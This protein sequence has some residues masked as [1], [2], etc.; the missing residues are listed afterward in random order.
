MNSCQYC[1]RMRK[2]RTCELSC[3]WNTTISGFARHNPHDMPSVIDNVLAFPSLPP[4]DGVLHHTSLFAP[5]TLASLSCCAPP[6]ALPSPST[7]VPDPP[8]RPLLSHSSS[9]RCRNQ[10]SVGTIWPLLLLRLV[11]GPRY[12]SHPKGS[13][14]R[15][16]REGSIFQRGTVSQ[17]AQARCD[18]GPHA[19]P[20][21][22]RR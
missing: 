7:T 2:A 14:D 15:R 18:S 13:P 6:V 11:H 21:R 17:Q 16:W 9:P 8:F 10:S 22:H 12:L 19:V 5:H 4:Y 3:T 1:I 20:N